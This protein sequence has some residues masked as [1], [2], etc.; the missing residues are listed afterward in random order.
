MAGLVQITVLMRMDDTSQKALDGLLSD[1]VNDLDCLD[2]GSVVG[3]KIERVEAENDLSKKAPADGPTGG[4]TP[5]PFRE[6]W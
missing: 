3:S 5:I 4:T 6:N 2:G 1:T